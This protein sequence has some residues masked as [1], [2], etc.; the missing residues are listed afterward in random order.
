VSWLFAAGMTQHV[1]V[2]LEPTGH[3]GRES[4]GAR[5]SHGL[6]FV[7]TIL[8]VAAIAIKLA[9]RQNLAVERGDENRIFRDLAALVDLRWRDPEG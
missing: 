8:A 6:Q 2:R 9:E 1:R 4:F 3:D 5:G 7:E